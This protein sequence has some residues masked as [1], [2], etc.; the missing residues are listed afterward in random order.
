MG[1][2]ENVPTTSSS[3]ISLFSRHPICFEWICFQKTHSW[4]L[5][6]KGTIHAQKSHFTWPG[7]KN[8]MGT[9]LEMRGGVEW[10][11][12]E[13]KTRVNYLPCWMES[14]G[15]F[16]PSSHVP[17]QMMCECVWFGHTCTFWESCSSSN[18]Q[19]NFLRFLTGISNFVLW[20][21]NYI[22]MCI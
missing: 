1:R 2:W 11:P 12:S 9:R 18:T 10:A 15:Y 22:G 17:I 3:V 14:S 21:T 4:T 7:S 20:R 16:F 8:A 13:V 6:E 5:Y 19:T